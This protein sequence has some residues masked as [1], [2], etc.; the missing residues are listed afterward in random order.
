MSWSSSYD[1]MSILK[2]SFKNYNWW[3]QGGPL[4]FWLSWPSSQLPFS[5]GLLEMDPLMR[6]DLD[7][8]IIELGFICGLWK[9]GRFTVVVFNLGHFPTRLF[10]A[11][12][13]LW[14]IWN[15]QVVWMSG[16]AFRTPCLRVRARRKSTNRRFVKKNI[17]LEKSRDWIL[18]TWRKV[19]IGFSKLGEK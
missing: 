7:L 8:K 6:Q 17:Y 18:K 1:Q 4:A 2:E 5:R 10:P 11:F 9:A 3:C 16:K 14:Q 19:G 15:N 12:S 13:F